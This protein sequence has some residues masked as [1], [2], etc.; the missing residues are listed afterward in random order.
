MYDEERCK[1]LERE[2]VAGGQVVDPHHHKFNVLLRSILHD[3]L[4]DRFQLVKVQLFVTV[5]IVQV[6]QSADLF[7]NESAQSTVDLLQLFGLFHHGLLWLEDML[8]HKRK[9]LFVGDRTIL[10]FVSI[11]EDELSA[12]IINFDPEE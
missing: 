11:I 5:L 7:P 2:T 4:E 12:S 3:V 10:V 9:V 1:D 6:V 8:F